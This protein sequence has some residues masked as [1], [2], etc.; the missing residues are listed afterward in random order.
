MSKPATVALP[1]EGL[2][3][4]QSIFIAVVLPAPFAPRKPKISPAYTSKVISLVA[5]KSPKR[6]VSLSVFITTSLV[7]SIHQIYKAIFNV[8]CDVFDFNTFK[9][10]F[11]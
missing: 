1:D 8:W 3:S 5:M 9:I 6:L 2:E 4:P 7:I 11:L 10:G